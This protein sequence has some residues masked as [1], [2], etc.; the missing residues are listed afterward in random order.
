MSQF[1][2]LKACM[3]HINMISAHFYAKK[4]Q[5]STESKTSISAHESTTAFECNWLP[6][7]IFGPTYAL[8]PS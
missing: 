2:N 5:Q 6:V 4:L 7:L 1:V 3:P 8:N